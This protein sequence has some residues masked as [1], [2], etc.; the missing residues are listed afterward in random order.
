MPSQ[1]AASMSSPRCVDRLVAAVRA[2]PRDASAL[3][4][5]LEEERDLSELFALASF[6]DDGYQRVSLFMCPEFEVRLICWRPGQ[7]SPVHGHGA[8]S[9]A[10]LTLR[11]EAT[12]YLMDGRVRTFRAGETIAAGV[13]EIH[14]VSNVAK[15]DLITLH[16]YSPPL[17]LDQAATESGHRV[18]ILGGSAVALEAATA[19]LRRPRNDLRIYLIDAGAHI[20]GPESNR[21]LV[22]ELADAVLTQ[23]NKIRLIRV[24]AVDVRQEGTQFIV[25]LADGR[26][27][28][29]D[30]LLAPEG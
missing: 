8:S 24:A 15:D 22:A 30:E 2:G 23:R 7:S 4:Q 27:L 19:Q 3:A 9:C 12:E 10:Y 14:Q 18:L 16:L 26:V 21:A 20:G 11:G 5:I 13:G 1:L 29:G 28:R 6:S 17:P 25:T